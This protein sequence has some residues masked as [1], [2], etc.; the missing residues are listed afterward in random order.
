MRHF[1]NYIPH[2]EVDT[3]AHVV[4]HEEISVNDIIEI[5]VTV[6][7]NRKSNFCS[8]TNYPFLK[9]EGWYMIASE[10]NYIISLEHFIF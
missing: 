2:I 4:G 3:I 10:N 7:T 5:I 8:S 1:L 6:K 9:Q